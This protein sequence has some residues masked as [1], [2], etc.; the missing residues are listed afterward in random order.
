MKL[1]RTYRS[2]LSQ[3][4]LHVDLV[5]DTIT[6]RDCVHQEKGVVQ[7]L[8]LAGTRRRQGKSKGKGNGIGKDKRRQVPR[9]SPMMK[10]SVI[11]L[12]PFNLSQ[13]DHPQ[14][15]SFAFSLIRD[16]RQSASI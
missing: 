3:Y 4:P 16:Y 12:K 11:Q 13:L 6:E 14:K 2:Q 10:D 15:S 7:S 9:S 8:Q 5:Q 1:K